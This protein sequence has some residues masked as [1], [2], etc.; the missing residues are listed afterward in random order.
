MQASD[1]RSLSRD[2]ISHEIVSAFR[3]FWCSKS[4]SSKH[5]SCKGEVISSLGIKWDYC[6]EQ[7]GHPRNC[8]KTTCLVATYLSGDLF[9]LLSV[10]DLRCVWSGYNK[11]SFQL[12]VLW[13]CLCCL[14]RVE[15]SYHPPGNKLAVRLEAILS[16]HQPV[17]YM[18]VDKPSLIVVQSM[19]VS[20]HLFCF[21]VSDAE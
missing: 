6:F 16:E 13:L 18:S 4:L 20:C 11:I 3:A 12:Q 8:L 10:Q 17:C 21:T 9:Y 7:R 5:L 15:V 2:F 19:L 14:V 1:W